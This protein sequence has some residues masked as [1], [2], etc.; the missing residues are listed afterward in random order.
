[1]QAGNGETG[2]NIASERKPR[3]RSRRR[4]L[5]CP[6]HP[7]QKLVGNGKKYFLHLLSPEQLKQR[8]M[9]DGKA[10]LVINAF[11]VLVLSNEWI[12][13][14]FCAECGACHWCHVMRLDSV[15]H[16]VRWAPRDLWQQ[17][18]HVDPIGGNPSVS[19]FTARQARRHSR[20]RSD[21]KAWFG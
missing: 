11:P 2:Q 1:M 17:V 7:E 18:A 4:E 12:E 14:L 10:R 21:G 19:Q 6:A 5:L 15:Q 13:E 16:T 20:K 9:P 8:G 3:Q